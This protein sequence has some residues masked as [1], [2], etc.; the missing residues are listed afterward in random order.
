MGG[1]ADAVSENINSRRANLILTSRWVE[2]GV[3]CT[4]T[5]PRW[6][7]QPGWAGSRMQPAKTSTA[8]GPTLFR[9]VVRVAPLM[10]RNL[11]S[12]SGSGCDMFLRRSE[13]LHL[14]WVLSERSCFA[15]AFFGVLVPG[16]EN[17]ILKACF[18]QV[19]G[20]VAQAG[21]A[22]MALDVTMKNPRAFGSL[23]SSL[24]ARSCSAAEPTGSPSSRTG[25]FVSA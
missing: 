15:F 5:S 2:Y 24:G 10:S 7:W 9:I 12:P 13:A 18:V 25:V 8:G 11:P 21:L 19:R 3:E 20:G 22:S 17:R 6:T 23:P 16:P 1:L 4:A 14:G